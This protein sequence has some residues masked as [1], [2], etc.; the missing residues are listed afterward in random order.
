MKTKTKTLTVNQLHKM[1]GKLVEEGNG[2]L[3]VCVSKSTFTHPC[4]DDGCTILNAYGVR[5]ERVLIAD[6]DG[7]MQFT[8]SGHEVSQR[9][10]LI[11]G[12]S[13]DEWQYADYPNHNPTP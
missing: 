9:T 8:Q 10:A 5:V 4:E 12:Y 2:R 7:G 3:P 13:D 6:G 1:L 11:F